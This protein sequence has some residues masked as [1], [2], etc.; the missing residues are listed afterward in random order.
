[1]TDHV[2][3]KPMLMCLTQ[4]HHLAYSVWQC[5]KICLK[6]V[7][8][9]LLATQ[10]PACLTPHTFKLISNMTSTKKIFNNCGLLI[11]IVA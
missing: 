10:Y 6:T 5:L 1:M 3:T 8:W 9:T 4:L 11:S 7:N 2:E